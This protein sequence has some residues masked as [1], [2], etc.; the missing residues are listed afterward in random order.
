MFTIV[1][2]NQRKKYLHITTVDTLAIMARKKNKITVQDNKTTFPHKSDALDSL[3]RLSDSMINPR[4]SALLAFYKQFLTATLLEEKAKEEQLHVGQ[5]GSIESLLGVYE[6]FPHIPKKRVNSIYSEVAGMKVEQTIEILL[7]VD[8]NEIMTDDNE[9]PISLQVHSQSSSK[10][11]TSDLSLTSALCTDIDPAIAEVEMDYMNAVRVKILAKEEFGLVE[12][13]S[14]HEYGFVELSE[15][16]LN[17][18]ESNERE[19]YYEMKVKKDRMKKESEFIAQKLKEE[20]RAR[21]ARILC[22]GELEHLAKN[23]TE[24]KRYNCPLTSQFELI[25]ELVHYRLVESQFYRLL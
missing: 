21:K 20:K 15:E 24:L 1:P 3:E 9:E 7:T 2:Q 12:E 17:N 4:I 19:L 11:T 23:T 22:E 18:M 8:P 16:E 13:E 5:D 6:M 14:Q 10:V 25:G